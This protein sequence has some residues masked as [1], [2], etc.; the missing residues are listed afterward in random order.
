MRAIISALV[1]CG[2]LHSRSGGTAGAAALP[3]PFIKLGNKSS[4]LRRVS[5]VEF[6]GLASL[7]SSF[8]HVLEDSE[9]KVSHCRHGFCVE[10]GGFPSLT[11]SFMYVLEESELVMPADKLNELGGLASLTA[12]VLAAAELA[13]SKS[14]WNWL[15]RPDSSKTLADC[16]N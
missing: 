14:R 6:G 7:T 4:T 2:L 10:L 13:A 1:R 15:V 8:R 9:F 11:C 3:K 12:Y 5:R 16:W